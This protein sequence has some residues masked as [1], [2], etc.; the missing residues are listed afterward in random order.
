MKYEAGLRLLGA[1]RSRTA[2]QHALRTI[3]AY[4]ALPVATCSCCKFEGRFDSFG[5][6]ARMGANCPKCE[7]KERHRLLAL[8]MQ[9]GE[10]VFAAKD[11][12]HFAPEAIVRKLVTAQKPRSFVG[13]D[14]EPGRAD[15]EL[16][17]EK[18]ALPDQSYDRIICSHVLEHVDDAKAL[19]E[20]HR[21]LRPGGQL[22]VMVPII[23]GWDQTFE[24]PAL[25]SESDRELYNGQYDH[26]RYYGANL[27]NRI[28][29][30]GFHLSEITAGPRDAPKY[31]LERGKKIFVAQR[32]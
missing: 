26:V 24:D 31:G 23:E 28:R 19:A 29:G 20:L 25:V 12:L 14:I 32:G 6:R 11:V 15:L 5:L 21:V 10:L 3:D 17:L 4:K 9:R 30:A 13:A 18:I 16:N 22:I 1:L 2:R 8:A 7:S 27:R